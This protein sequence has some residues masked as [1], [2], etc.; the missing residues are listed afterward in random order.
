MRLLRTAFLSFLLL[1][2]HI[3][4]GTVEAQ[5][6][7]DR[8]EPAMGLFKEGRFDE[9]ERV[10]SDLIAREPKNYRAIVLRGRIACF[11]TTLVKRERT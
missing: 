1:S 8:L 10:C 2:A 11:P 4:H 6:T 3:I 7:Q 5:L 9:A